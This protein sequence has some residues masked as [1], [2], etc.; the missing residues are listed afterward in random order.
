MIIFTLAL[1]AMVQAQPKGEQSTIVYQ[2][3]NRKDMPVVKGANLYCAGYIQRASL[4][5]K[6]E[7][8]GATMEKDKHVYAQGDHLYLNSG[9]VDGV[10]VGDTFSVIRP[11]GKVRTKWSKKKLGHYI[12]EVG[13]VKVIK[14][15]RDVSVAKVVTS[16]G[17]IMFGDLLNP[18]PNRK[19]P[20][21]KRR[22]P[23][24]LYAMSSG[25]ANGKIV[26]A[27]DGAELLGREM[28]VYVDLGR[29]DSV[30]IG[31]YMT[32]YRKLGTG[33]LS[34]RVFNETVE[35]T[36]ENYE[37]GRYKGGKY[38]NQ[39]ARV[40]GAKADGRTVTTENAKT[41]RPKDLRRVVGELV[42]INVLERTATAVIVRNA[43]EIHTGDK[44]ELQ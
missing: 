32:V 40:K 7:I 5:T 22:A 14:V 37:S 10:K 9:A 25:K 36:S 26:M 38:S 28:I 43:T 17:I 27:R 44:V 33:N 21:F 11:R 35:N 31:D 19:S 24:D 1:V 42:V 13:A 4:S 2:D 12:Q 3:G 30:Q 16:C 34:Q 39:G 15:M 18:V 6:T 20:I 29:E 8:V 23:L 41:R